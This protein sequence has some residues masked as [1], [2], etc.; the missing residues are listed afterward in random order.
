MKNHLLIILFFS[1]NVLLAQE[2]VG[3]RDIYVENDLAFKVINDELFTGQAQKV[4]KNG[5]L[6]Y[7]EF[8]EKGV[9]LKSVVYYNGTEKPKPATLTEFYKNTFNKSKETTYGLFKPTLTIKHYDQDGN[10]TLVEE[11][12]NDKLTYRC[13]YLNNK[14][15]G[16]EFCF[17]NYGNELQTEYANGKKIVRE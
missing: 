4:R 14:K 12:E 16:T 5:H 11:Y 7:E 10:K 8:Y 15:H 3:L 13:E 6:V 2:K 17:D 9:P 1:F